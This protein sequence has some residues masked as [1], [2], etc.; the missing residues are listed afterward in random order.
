MNQFKRLQEDLQ[1]K[2]QLAE[3][4][5]RAVKKLMSKEPPLPAVSISKDKRPSVERNTPQA[6]SDLYMRDLAFQIRT[7]NM[8]EQALDIKPF[9]VERAITQEMI[10][11]YQAAPLVPIEIGGEKFKYNPSKIVLDLE[12]LDL[13]HPEVEFRELNAQV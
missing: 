5:N 8:T 2:K 3:I 7:D 6:I 12:V 9:K 4:N 11:D 13:P 10:D 1:L